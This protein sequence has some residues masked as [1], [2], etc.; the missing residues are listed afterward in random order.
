MTI[1]Q[2]LYTWHR[3]CPVM[4]IKK[5]NRTINQEGPIAIGKATSEAVQ[6]LK[7]S[8]MS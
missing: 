8:E 5:V 3:N 6:P 7:E 2:K 4:H 1:I